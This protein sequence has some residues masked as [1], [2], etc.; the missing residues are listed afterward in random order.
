MKN[1][2]KRFRDK[3]LTCDQ[4]IFELRKE[5]GDFPITPIII[6]TTTITIIRTMVLRLKPN[7]DDIY[8]HTTTK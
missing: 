7:N 8:T 6:Q 1:K 4:N 3:L 5:I 2:T